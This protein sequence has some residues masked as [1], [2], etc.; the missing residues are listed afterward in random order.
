MPV[1]YKIFRE[2]ALVAG[3]FRGLFTRAEFFAGIR[4]LSSDPDFE[5]RFARLAMFGDDL[6]LSEFGYGDLVAVKDAILDAYFG[7]VLPDKTGGDL[8]RIAAVSTPSA[9]K[10]IFNL[11]GAVLDT[12]MASLV[13]CKSFEDVESAVLRLSI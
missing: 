1:R 5:P 13:P 4:A 6:D 11:Y 7:G 9:N 10:A 8:F 3:H 2:H 12:G